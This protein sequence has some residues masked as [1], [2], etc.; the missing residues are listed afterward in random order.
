MNSSSTLIFNAYEFDSRMNY[1][2][3]C[4]ENGDQRFARSK[5]ELKFTEKGQQTL[6]NYFIGINWK[7]QA[8]RNRVTAEFG[9]G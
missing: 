7:L 8:A 6:V 1:E 9:I 4:N 3:C 2:Y 5:I